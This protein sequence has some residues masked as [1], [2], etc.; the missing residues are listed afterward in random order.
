MEKFE[1]I[2]LSNQ[3]LQKLAIPATVKIIV[4]GKVPDTIF[5][6]VHTQSEVMM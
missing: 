6:S 1:E 3:D 4:S 5:Q 2:I